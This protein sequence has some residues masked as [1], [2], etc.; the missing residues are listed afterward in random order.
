MKGAS[1]LIVRKDDGI[2][3]WVAEDRHSFDKVTPSMEERQDVQ[4][5]F[6][7]QDDSTGKTA[8]GVLVPVNSCDKP[9]DYE[10]E[11]RTTLFIWAFGESHSFS[12]HGDNRGQFSANLFRPHSGKTTTDL[13]SSY[14]SIDFLMVNVSSK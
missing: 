1:Q 7:W 6:A 10:L 9:Y 2:D 13:S 8:W 3:E 5:L 4:L 14:E 11:D 12:Y